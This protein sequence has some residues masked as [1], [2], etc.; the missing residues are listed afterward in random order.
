MMYSQVS[1]IC[2]YKLIQNENFIK[3]NNDLSDLKAT[4]RLDLKNTYELAKNSKYILKFNSNES[5]GLIDKSIHDSIKRNK[6]YKVAR[7]MVGEGIHC[8]NIEQN[9]SLWS[10]ELSS[11]NYLVEEPLN[12][13][14]K[15]TNQSKKI[16]R[17]NAIKAIP[18]FCQTCDK[19]LKE[20]WFTTE[21]PVPFGPDGL[22]GLP[23]L[24]IEI[25]HY[26]DK[27]TLE[28]IKFSNENLENY[29]PRIGK[30]I[31]R[32]AYNKLIDQL[33]N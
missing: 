26:S 13:K 27:L 3:I 18:L 1:S 24:I 10:T 33:R 31:T 19:S 9:I 15:I 17:Y 12:L 6:S 4:I 2:T 28:K 7:I 16:G 5:I 30:Q 20:V 22:G 11:V 8:Q 29:I 32:D 21:I 14:W 23:G 25:V